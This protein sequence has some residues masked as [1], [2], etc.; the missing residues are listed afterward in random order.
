VREFL[1][2]EVSVKWFTWLFILATLLLPIGRPAMAAATATPQPGLRTIYLIRHGFYD[3]AD[4]ADDRV[5]KHLVQL[6]R[7]QAILV[8][9]RLSQLPVK[10]TT[11]TSSML[12]RAMETG[13]LMGQ[14]LHMNVGR[15]SLLNECGPHRNYTGTSRDRDS[16]ESAAAELQLERAWAKYVRPSPDGDAHDVLVCHGNVIRWMT[17]KAMGVDTKQWAAM[18]IGNGSLTVIVVR[19]DGTTRLVTYSDV[20]HL[21]VDKQSWTG[22]GGNWAPPV[23]E[24]KR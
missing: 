11:L 5:G 18:D 19:P 17:C 13:D 3:R 22:R 20:G 6:G 4:S 8:G 23:A 24:V 16:T 7:D 2:R 1:I 10:M 15:D 12:T 14:A 21:P 9:H